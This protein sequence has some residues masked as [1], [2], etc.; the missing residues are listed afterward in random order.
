[1]TKNTSISAIALCGG[2]LEI[3]SAAAVLLRELPDTIHL[4]L[5]ET[6]QTY[7]SPA[8]T[9]NSE[10]SFHI[11]AGINEL[12]LVS[13]CDGTLSLGMAYPGWRGDGSSYFDA[14]AG[15]LPGLNGTALHHLLL[16][17]AVM[18]G[19]PDKLADLAASFRF[20]ALAALNGKLTHASDDPQS[21]RSMLRTMVHVDTAL[22]VDLLKRK[23]ADVRHVDVICS[24]G[25]CSISHDADGFIEAVKHRM[26]KLLRLICSLIWKIFLEATIFL[27]KFIRCHF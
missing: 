27:Y 5:I 11:R 13:Q 2:A 15:T 25:Q 19:E 20:P 12:E 17:A 23:A 8:L 14:P 26:A 3:W 22:Y 24:N 16:R 21:P 18:R 6:K 9:F 1:M 7:C 4:T 10:N